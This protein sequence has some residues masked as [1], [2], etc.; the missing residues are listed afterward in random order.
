M[1]QAIVTVLQNNKII[2]NN[3]F[4]NIQEAEEFFKKECLKIDKSLDYDD[5]E[6]CLDDGF[7][8]NGEL[9]VCINSFNHDFNST[10]AVICVEN[11]CI[12]FI[13][14]HY[15]E[16]QLKEVYKDL[17]ELHASNGG[18]YSAEDIQKCMD[19]GVE[20]IN[21]KIKIYFIKL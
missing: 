21:S 13:A 11:N 9:T 5:L 3:N 7:L 19:N 1:K 20:N 18:E 15:N 14:I 10:Y 16:Y 6:N 17:L 12:D 8:D 2:T 4:Y